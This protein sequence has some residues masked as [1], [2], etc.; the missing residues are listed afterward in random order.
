[1][2]IE[3]FEKYGFILELGIVITIF[4]LSLEKR[5][6]F[7][8]HALFPIIIS[9]LIMFI[10]KQ[11]FPD[12]L[13]TR[14][15]LFISL[16]L[17]SIY[18]IHRSFNVTLLGAIYCAVGANAA[19]H[20]I[21]TTA[22]LLLVLSGN[23]NDILIT[24]IIYVGFTTVSY[25]SI[26]FIFA[27]NFKKF[28]ISKMENKNVII[29]GVILLI[30]TTIISAFK[31]EYIP[32]TT[33]LPFVLLSI[34]DIFLCLFTLALQYNISKGDMMKEE[35]KI[36][37][38]LLVIQKKQME[39][40]KHN[41]DL[42]NVK[43]HDMKHYISNIN[44]RLSEQEI[45]ELDE[46]IGI[47]NKSLITGNE[48]LDIL[49]MEKSLLYEKNKVTL[50]CIADG[51][52]LRNVSFSDIYSLFGNALDNAFE[53]VMQIENPNK[54]I[55][56]IHIKEVMGFASIHI[57]NNFI[58]IIKWDNDLPITTKKNKDFHGFGTKSI[59]MIVDKYKGTISYYIE[60]N[61][62]NLD[63]ILPI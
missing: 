6:K 42:I 63:I 60:N 58:G 3:F 54:R 40:S 13:Y 4:T 1:M 57:Q 46:M 25:I 37:E 15:S 9:F 2:F 36:L 33:L 26:Y 35:S 28:E 61:V 48:A 24:N 16:F 56:G 30:F 21:Y 17:V 32:S 38:H 20:G 23:F 53:A 7:Y 55:I 34:Y 22:S 11:F 14:M 59:K 27:K 44:D 47:Y 50:D 5:K 62:F 31:K 49:L 52:S 8:I 10:F 29:L 19:Q 18:G 51:N 45:E 43:Y 12:N 41:I 39:I